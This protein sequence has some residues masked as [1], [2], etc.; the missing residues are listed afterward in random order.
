MSLLTWFEQTY[1]AV[2]KN[3]SIHLDQKIAK[4]KEEQTI[5]DSVKNIQTSQNSFTRDT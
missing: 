1:L 4:K 2:E 3:G 5:R